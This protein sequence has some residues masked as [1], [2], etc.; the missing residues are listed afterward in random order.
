MKKNLGL[1]VGGTTFALF[2]TEAVIHYNMG[3]SE[4]EPDHR[5]TIPKKQDLTKLA[6]VVGI[7][8]ILNGV[9]VNEVKKS[10]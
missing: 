3:V 4:K 2:M 5:F 6:V 8:S 10:I 1:I 9:I 7:F